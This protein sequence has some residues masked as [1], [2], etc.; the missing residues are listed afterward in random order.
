MN[1]RKIKHVFNAVKS[2]VTIAAGVRKKIQVSSSV[3]LTEKPQ[4]ACDV[5]TANT[6][7]PT[8][9]AFVSSGEMALMQT[10]TTTIK[11]RHSLSKVTARILLDSRSQRSYI[12]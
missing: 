9:N 6:F 11:N 10:A 12:S 5:H 4:A 2:I 3:H 7:I 1:V 8:E